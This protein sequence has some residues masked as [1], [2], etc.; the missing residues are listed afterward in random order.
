M[1]EK[2]QFMEGNPD[3]NKQHNN[4]QTQMFFGFIAQLNERHP[5]LVAGIMNESKRAAQEFESFHGL[6]LSESARL[7][8]QGK[9]NSS[10]FTGIMYGK[11]L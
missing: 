8:L 3:K 5:E 6:Q 2:I 10:V 9:L 7:D 4:W 1:K 11:H